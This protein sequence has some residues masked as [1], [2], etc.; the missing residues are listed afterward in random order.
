MT[1]SLR[2]IGDQR[3]VDDL[4]SFIA[5]PA[6]GR[7]CIVL[8]ARLSGRSTFVDTACRAAGCVVRRWT[9][10]M[11]IEHIRP[12]HGSVAAF[13]ATSSKV[14]AGQLEDASSQ[15]IATTAIVID[16]VDVAV[17]GSRG[18]QQHIIESIARAPP[19][20]CFVMV[21]N[22][23]SEG[24]SF[25]QL[26]A[27]VPK[28]VRLAPPS[29]AD[30]LRGLAENLQ[31]EDEGDTAI[32]EAIERFVDARKCDMCRVASDVDDL[33]VQIATILVGAAAI[34]TQDASPRHELGGAQHS[35]SDD[36]DFCGFTFGGWRAQ[37]QA[38][39]RSGTT[40]TPRR[41]LA[42]RF[43]LQ[44]TA[45]LLRAQAAASCSDALEA[46]ADAIQVRVT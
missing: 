8:G 43:D 3:L 16:D 5:T 29:R 15:P 19:H 32:S 6:S 24:K 10:D 22:A 46:I 17:A 30:I 13:F 26:L 40:T 11:P 9:M 21:A 36:D 28:A 41:L 20:T 14:P 23:S 18:L 39:S 1:S 4:A 25:R 31:V 12:C 38:D 42:R 44:V 35:T 45:Q 33:A 27:A 37:A 7:A 2:Y 34:T